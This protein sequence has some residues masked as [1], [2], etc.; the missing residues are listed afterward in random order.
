MVSLVPG[1]SMA[2][3]ADGLVKMA[4][5]QVGL[6]SI[7]TSFPEPGGVKD[8]RVMSTNGPKLKAATSESPVWKKQLQLMKPQL[9]R[10]TRMKLQPMRQLLMTIQQSRLTHKKE[11]PATIQA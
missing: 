6:P 1:Q 9:M 3:L 5:R 11:N 7:Q 10:Q 8:M 4:H 2:I